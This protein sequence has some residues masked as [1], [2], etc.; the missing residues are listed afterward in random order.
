[1]LDRAPSQNDILSA[2]HAT[3]MV[4]R[5]GRVAIIYALVG[6][7]WILLSDKAVEWLIAERGATFLAQT[8]K[9]I[10]YVFLSTLL[11]YALARSAFQGA[12]RDILKGQLERTQ[13]LFD[14]VLANL[15][16]AVFVID[17]ARHSIVRCN[18]AVARVFGYSEAELIGKRMDILHVDW[19]SFE[20]FGR[21]SKI[22]LDNHIAF[23]TRFQMKRKDGGIIETEN[24]V[25]ALDRTV[26]WPS[27]VVSI[28]RDV[29]PQV[30]AERAL[31]ISEEHYRLLADNTLDVI[32]T[33]DAD[34]VLTY[35]NPAVA[36]ILGYTP[37][38]LI[39]T[40]LQ[41][42]CRPKVYDD[43]VTIIADETAKGPRASGTIME[44]E[45]RC[46]DGAQLPVE[47]HGKVL[48]DLQ[49][50][51]AGFQCTVRDISERLAME[52]QLRQSQKLEA[53]GTLASSVAHEINNP[54]TGIAGYADLL[55]V[56]GYGR[57]EVARF[58]SEIKA[59]VQRV[60]TIVQNLLG[61]AR[62]EHA[63]AVAPQRIDEIVASMLSLVRTI[64]RHDAITLEVDI[65]DGLPGIL[66]RK[67]QM[68][69][70]VMNLL[71]NA[72]D[73]LNS[74]YPSRH[75]DKKIT[76]TAQTVA[77]S[78]R[79]FVRT[80]IAD[81]G[82]GITD[83]VRERI[84]D[85]FFTTKPSETGTGLGMWITYSIIKEHGGEISIE[86]E[87]GQYTRFHIDLPTTA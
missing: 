17:N 39:G 42:H 14:T 87:E 30:K 81:R 59:A 13:K 3:S 67:Q 52:A 71:T 76:I 56:G 8:I 63:E 79:V 74:K 22:A 86:T 77:K 47:I 58:A 31:K 33:M 36:P 1:V 41:E 43:L 18:T 60:R 51:I 68:Q 75:E 27:G 46:K 12:E 34:L 44:T 9:G 80:T 20:D 49:H 45:I 37:E 6:I 28:V 23:R 19:S 21:V 85:P 25:I 29:T 84:F 65:P 35:V 78:D 54:M 50:R 2:Q 57:E 83:D 66:C 53:I 11:V 38:E 72:R 55:M 10:L 73:A 24:T 82:P 16:E 70:V 48:F 5:A 15:G 40:A 69:Q 32:L 62:K 61:F 4:S 7:A 26:G 64:M